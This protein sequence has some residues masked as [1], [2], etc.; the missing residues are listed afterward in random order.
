MMFHA[1]WNTNIVVDNPL[2]GGTEI[3][4]G[5]GAK[6]QLVEVAAW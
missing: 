1:A 5:R 4:G 3:G 2:Q 6:Q